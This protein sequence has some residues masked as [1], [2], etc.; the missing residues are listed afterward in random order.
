M[1]QEE[2]TLNDSISVSLKLVKE[3]TLQLYFPGQLQLDNPLVESLTRDV[4]AEAACF[5]FCSCI[6]RQKCWI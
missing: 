3:C 4:A 2:P 5:Q 1:L 6:W